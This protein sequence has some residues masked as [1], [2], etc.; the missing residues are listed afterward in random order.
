MKINR[1]INSIL[2]LITGIIGLALSYSGIVYFLLPDIQN[3]TNIIAGVIILLIGLLFLSHTYRLVFFAIKDA[4]VNGEPDDEK[5]KLK[6]HK[7]NRIKNL[8][9]LIIIIAI[10]AYG[11][12]VLGEAELLLN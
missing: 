2:A 3:T 7:I 11:F 4:P 8:I 1:I 9:G 10:I 6:K 5:T 12:W